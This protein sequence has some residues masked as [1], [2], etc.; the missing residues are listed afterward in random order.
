LLHE[1]LNGRFFAGG[2]LILAAIAISLL[3]ERMRLVP[4]ME[5]QKKY[6]G[7]K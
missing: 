7:L 3:P 1:S 4:R 2:A 6:I 5:T